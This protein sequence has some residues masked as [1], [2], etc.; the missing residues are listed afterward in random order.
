MF[1]KNTSC[2]NDHD[3]LVVHISET[4]HRGFQKA[5]LVLN[6]TMVN[7]YWKIGQ[8]IIE[9]EQKGKKNSN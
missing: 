6:S 5:T 8:S 2:T 3:G 9:F 7:T 1:S 4:Y